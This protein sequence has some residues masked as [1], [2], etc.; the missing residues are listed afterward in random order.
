MSDFCRATTRATLAAAVLIA[1]GPTTTAAQEVELVVVD[2]TAVAKGYS[3]NELIGE[4]VMN[5]RREPI[6]TIDD[7]VITRADDDSEAYAVLEVGDFV[8]FGGHLVAV[9]FTSLEVDEQNDRI[10]LAGA[11]REALKKLPVYQGAS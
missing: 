1:L 8:G 2:P 7:L 10:V 4:T 5:E 3:A 11:T 6:G 9:P